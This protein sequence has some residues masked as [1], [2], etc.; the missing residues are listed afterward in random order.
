MWYQQFGVL[1]ILFLFVILIGAIGGFRSGMIVALFSIAGIAFSIFFYAAF[2]QI[3]RGFLKPWVENMKML[4]YLTAA[5]MFGVMTI[6][7]MLTGKIVQRLVTMTPLGIVDKLLGG[8]IGASKWFFFAGAISW[9]IGKANNTIKEQYLD[10]AAS[11]RFVDPMMSS[12]M[13]KITAGNDTMTQKAAK[14]QPSRRTV[15]RTLKS[16]PKKTRNKS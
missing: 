10:K 8:I 15:R 11:Y 4:P 16:R 5:L 3:A 1:D 12:L 2:S 7:S 13:N 14:H 9:M 6:V